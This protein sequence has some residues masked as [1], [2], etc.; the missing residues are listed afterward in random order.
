MG[1]SRSRD[2]YRLG[3]PVIQD[4]PLTSYPTL[5]FLAFLFT[6][7]TERAVARRGSEDRRVISTG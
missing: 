3:K 1:V 7:T 5:F 4:T 2:D 6:P